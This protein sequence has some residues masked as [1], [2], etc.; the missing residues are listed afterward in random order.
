MCRV[1][2]NVICALLTI[3]SD[4]PVRWKPPDEWRKYYCCSSSLG[5]C[6]CVRKEKQINNY[7]INGCLFS[8]RRG[9]EK[10]SMEMHNAEKEKEAEPLN[11]GKQT[12]ARTKLGYFL[13]CR[14]LHVLCAISVLLGVACVTSNSLGIGMKRP[15]DNVAVARHLPC[16]QSLLYAR[17]ALFTVRQRLCHI[18]LA[19]FPLPL[20]VP[21]TFNR[22][23]RCGEEWH[24]AMFFL[25]LNFNWSDFCFNRHYLSNELGQPIIIDGRKSAAKI[26]Y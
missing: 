5:V 11:E 24:Q 21:R 6:L 8:R 25:G 16:R 23:P 7:E 15:T 14:V 1:E 10:S 4:W 19:L 9:R 26:L 18:I 12:D 3:P 2:P 20:L 13:L 17:K 22:S